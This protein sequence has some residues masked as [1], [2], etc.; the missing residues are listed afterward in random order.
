MTSRRSFDEIARNDLHFLE[1]SRRLFTL[2]AASDWS[3]P[4]CCARHA[5]NVLNWPWDK[6][7]LV[8][9]APYQEDIG[10]Q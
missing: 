9:N 5:G 10:S 2:K 1:S 4:A 8:P 6:W 7:D 3:C